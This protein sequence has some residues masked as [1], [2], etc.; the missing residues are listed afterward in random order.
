MSPQDGV[1]V[2]DEHIDASAL[3]DDHQPDRVVVP[4]P[5]EAAVRLADR[6]HLAVHGD[7]LPAPR[8]CEHLG[9]VRGVQRL[10]P[11]EVVSGFVGGAAEAVRVKDGQLTRR[12][13]ID[14]LGPGGAPGAEGPRA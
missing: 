14:L 4:E 1:L 7:D 13:R 11:L 10:D 3:E 8:L 12:P 9:F 6:Q 2:I 5:S